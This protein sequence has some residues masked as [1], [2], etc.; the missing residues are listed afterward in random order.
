[1]GELLDRNF[2]RELLQDLQ[3]TYPR[4]LDLNRS[5]GKQT[6]NRLLVNLSYLH[7]HGMVDLKASNYLSG[8]ISLHHAKIT[9]KGMDF[10]ADDGGLSAILGVVTIKIHEDTI[11]DILLS[12]LQSTDGDPTVK[13]QLIDKIKSLPSE[14]LGSL[15]EKLLNAGLDQLPDLPAI[16]GKWLSP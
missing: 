16:L 8:D 1:M 6:D 14:A 3:T 2:Q 15:T 13:A 11:R 10:L 9:A 7:E 12:R 4:A 5:Y